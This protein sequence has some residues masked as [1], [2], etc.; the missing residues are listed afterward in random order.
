MNRLDVVAIESFNLGKSNHAI[1]EAVINSIY[2]FLSKSYHLASKEEL[3]Q[4]IIQPEQEGELSV[5]LGLN[6]SIAGLSRTTKQHLQ[7]GRKKATVFTVLMFLNPQYKPSSAL[8]NAGLTQGMSYKLAHPREEIAYIAFA[9]MPFSYKLL[10]KLSDSFY[11]KPSQP[12]PNQIKTVVDAVKKQNGWVSTGANPMIV[13][14]PLVP[15]RGQAVHMPAEQDELDEFYLEVNPDYMQGKA[16]LTYI[17]LNLANINYGLK[18]I[19][20]QPLHSGLILNYKETNP[21][22]FKLPPSFSWPS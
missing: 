15:I 5:L 12:V 2:D 13:H 22:N 6:G 1:P 17:P 3:L 9:N 21:T 4:L 18:I 19:T 11:P 10:N 14:S 8:V 16:L 7:V 20:Q